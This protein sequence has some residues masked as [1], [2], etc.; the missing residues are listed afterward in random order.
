MSYKYRISRCDVSDK[1]LLREFRAKRSEWLRWLAG[2]DYHSIW[3]QI[4]NMIYFDTIFKILNKAREISIKSKEPDTGLNPHLLKLLDHGFVIHQTTL[5]RR[6]VEKPKKSKKYAV[7]SLRRVLSDLRDH[8]HLITRENFVSYDGLPYDPS[9]GEQRFFKKVVKNKNPNGRVSSLPLSGRNGW[10]MSEKLHAHFDKI[11]K[12]KRKKRSRKETINPKLIDFLETRLKPCDEIK[13]YVD[14]FVAHAADPITRE[15]ISDAE[16][17]VTLNK[18]DECYKGIYQVA[19]FICQTLLYEAARFPF[20]T[21][22][23]DVFKNLDKKW[24]SQNKL[25][26]LELVLD[27]CKQV[28][29]SWMELEIPKKL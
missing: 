16:K 23:D 20:P 7:Y 27:N 5:L 22:Q 19:S 14:K 24:L 10:A 8:H 2:D 11:R 1:A 21:A 18:L 28:A 25:S 29:E 17:G 3:G 13:V 12:D 15:S 26:E 4:Y 9:I 6:L